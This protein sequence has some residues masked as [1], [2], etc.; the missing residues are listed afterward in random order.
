MQRT[1]AGLIEQKKRFAVLALARQCWQ[2]DDAAMSQHLLALA[3][4]DAPVTGKE[5]LP[6][7]HTALAFLMES[8]Q[9]AA[10]DGLVGKLLKDAEHARRPDLWRTAAH[11]ADQRENPARRLEC[12][13]KA[14]ELEFAHLPWWS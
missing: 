7:Y 14:L 10:A 4:R 9:T 5:A 3:L 2:L 11:L 13:E 12:L 8:N 1:A 6:L